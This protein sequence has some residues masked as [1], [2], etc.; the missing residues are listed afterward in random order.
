MINNNKLSIPWQQSLGRLLVNFVDLIREKHVIKEFVCVAALSRQHYAVIGQDAQAGAS[1][2]DG[3]HGILHLVQ[4]P[5][6]GEDGCF[7]VIATSL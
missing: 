4:P 6:R 1:V 3:L 2:A 5:L 7:R